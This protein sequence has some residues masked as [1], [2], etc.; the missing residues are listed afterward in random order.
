M[1][2]L[3]VFA[4]YSYLCELERRWQFGQFDRSVLNF[5]CF[6]PRFAL[7]HAVR[8]LDCVIDNSFTN[9]LWSVWF[10]TI[11]TSYYILWQA[12]PP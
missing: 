6:K 10:H 4:M 5:N 12:P 1:S 9:Y 7:K 8:I 11:T 2:E 3:L